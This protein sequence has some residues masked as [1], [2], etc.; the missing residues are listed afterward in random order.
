MVNLLTNAIKF[1]DKNKKQKI[2]RIEME[3]DDKTVKIVVED[4]GVGI[5]A[6]KLDRILINSTV[7]I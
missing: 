4:N 2:V 3:N 6:D 7:L 1:S 5:P